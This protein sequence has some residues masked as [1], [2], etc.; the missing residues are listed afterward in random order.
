MRSLLRL[1][2][3]RHVA[4]LRYAT[5]VFLGTLIIWISLRGIGD[6]NPVWAI[7]SFVVVSDPDLGV[8]W[9]S[10]VSRFS[11]TLIGCTTGVLCLFVFG[12]KDWLLAPVLALTILVCTNMIRLPGSWKI[13]PA[14]SALVIT[15][16]LVENSSLIGFEQALRRAGEVLFGSLVALLIS[17]M[18]SRFWPTLGK[19]LEQRKHINR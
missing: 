5:D 15:S 11:N 3:L 9:P 19:Q 18:L 7:I 13:A 1:S 14:T 16:A 6:R 12:L 17:W 10:F 8:A 4:G 2:F